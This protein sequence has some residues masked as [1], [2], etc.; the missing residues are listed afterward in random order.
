MS[1]GG[2]DRQER[3]RVA[4]GLQLAVAVLAAVSLLP[5]AGVALVF[6]GVAGFAAWEWAL[7]LSLR[8]RRA[9]A[10]VAG[11]ELLLAALWF[12][13]LAP[14][15]GVALYLAAG[16]WFFVFVLVS[17]YRPD[18]CGQPWLQ[19]CLRAGLPFALAGAWVATWRLHQSSAGL[20]LYLLLLVSLSDV[21]AYYAG[22]RWG[23]R[24]LSPDLSGGK[25]VAGLWGGVAC[26]AVLAVAAALA[27]KLVA[28]TGEAGLLYLLDVVLL[29]LFA[30]LAGVV[31]D[32]GV[33]LLKRNAGAK[34]SGSL[35][36][37]HGGVLDRVDSTLAA[38]PVFAIAHQ[39][40]FGT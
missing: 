33:S 16:W 24:K 14:L 31:G 11:V 3:R 10:V 2:A 20:L 38:A 39:L 29:S 40:A 28:A 1:R 12:A 17:S 15:P 34:D 13:P 30:V 4:T 8:G 27:L 9:A 18:W 23:K 6:A 7:L 37:G 32:L 21:G 5:T 36:P 35:L 19:R 25:T 26:A 22:R